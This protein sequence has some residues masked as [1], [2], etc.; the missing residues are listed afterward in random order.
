MDS[1]FLEWGN[2]FAGESVPTMNWR[3]LATLPSK[4]DRVEYD[5]KCDC[6]CGRNATSPGPAWSVM[7]IAGACSGIKTWSAFTT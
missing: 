5:T 1:A 2:V 3:R 6:G 4:M 7:R